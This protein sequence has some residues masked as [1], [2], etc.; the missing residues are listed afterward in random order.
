MPEREIVEIFDQSGQVVDRVSREDAESANHITENV[1]VFVFNSLGRVWIQLRP[2]SKAHYPGKWDIS[3]CGG[4]HADET[5]DEAA[6][7]E[8]LEETGL[9][10]ELEYVES[11]MNVFPGDNG[12][13]RRRLSRLYVG[14]SDETP[15]NDDGEVDEFR[16]YDPDE[17][18]AEVIKNEDDY[19]PSFLIELEKAVEYYRYDLAS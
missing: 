6:K 18:R 2:M 13:T 10:L 19:I 8:T 16:L 11:F 17:L 3:A 7:R 14:V 9:D 5:S 15:F 12:E 1:L 4:V